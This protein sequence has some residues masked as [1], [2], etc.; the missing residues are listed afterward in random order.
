MFDNL[1]RKERVKRL[2]TQAYQ[3]GAGLT[4]LDLEWLL[5]VNGAFVRQMLDA[6]HERFGV[7]LPTAGMILHM[8]R[9]LTHKT[10]VVEMS[11]SGMSTQEIARRIYHSPE[12]V[13]QC[14]KTFDRID[15]LT[16]IFKLLQT[17][18]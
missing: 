15:Q 12:A 3:Q 11:L 17:R 2:C 16:V 1:G 6:C 4:M 5:G 7:L 8:G 9:T 13:D 10:I 18:A 14:L